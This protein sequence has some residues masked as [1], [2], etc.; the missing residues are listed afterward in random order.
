MGFQKWINWQRFKD[1][2][3][4]KLSMT[5]N[6]KTQKLLNMKKKLMNYLCLICDFST[7]EALAGRLPAGAL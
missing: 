7:N 4:V 6:L 2:N 3:T 1:K 5:K